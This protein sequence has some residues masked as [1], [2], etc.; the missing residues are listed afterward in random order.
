MSIIVSDLGYHFPDRTNLFEHL[1]FTVAPRDK[2]A[3]IG[4]NG[5]GKS[6][7]LQLISGRLQPAEGSVLYA[8]IPYYVPQHIGLLNKT[9]AEALGVSAKLKALEAITNGSLS[10]A[11]YDTLADDWEIEQRATDALAYWGLTGINPDASI[12]KLSGGEKTKVFLAGLQIHQPEVVLLDEPTNHLD[13]SARMLLYDYI[14]YSNATMLIVSHDITLLDRLHTTYELSERGVR[15]Y[16]GNYSFYKEQKEI[17]ANALDDDI[18]EEEK[19]LRLARRRAIEVSQRQEKRSRKGEERSSELPRIMRKNTMNKAENSSARLKGKHDEIIESGRER[20]SGLMRKKEM[21]KSLKIDF[22]N[23]S[24]HT[25][26]L[27]LDAKQINHAYGSEPLWE[28]PIDFALYSGDRVHITG[29]NG[30]GKSTL[31]RLLLGELQPSEGEVARVPFSYVYLDQNYTRMNADC[32][33]EEMA[34]RYNYARLQEHEI[35]TRLNRALFPASMWRKKCDV[36][37]GGEKM[38]LYL[39]C[40]M[41][42]NHTPDLFVLDEP[43]N[44]LDIAS[45]QILTQ[46]I[47]EYRGS[48]LV[49][50][51]DGYFVNEIGVDRVL[52][53]K[54]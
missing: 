34:E 22:E 1:N 18:R 17:E 16:G 46:T 2:A 40:L 23:A 20:L 44:N 27:L 41:L 52:E 39:C 29:D 25:G 9:I 35:K 14:G 11:D 8:S 13:Y 38:R 30:S 48:L 24:L 10:V 26:K 7:L 28:T 6:T 19:S 43:T 51:H 54:N 50:S 47:K 42:S 49:I 37:S 36:L 15:L 33:V 45:L 12:D 32:T 31:I 5:T 21:G 4:N 3:L 53:I